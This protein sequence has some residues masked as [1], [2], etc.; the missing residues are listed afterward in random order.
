MSRVSFFLFGLF[1]AFGASAAPNQPMPVRGYADIHNHMF[2]E[3]AYGGAWYHGSAVGPEEIALAACDVD[4]DLLGLFEKHG[5]TKIPFVNR[6]ITDIR[7]GHADSGRHE[8]RRDG[9]PTYEGWPRWDTMSHQQVWEGWLKSAHEK[10]LSLVVISAVNFEPLCQL[11]PEV[12]RKVS[13]NDMEAV[14]RQIAAVHE[15]AKKHPWAVV[16]SSPAEARRAIGS[17]KLALVLSLEVTNLFGKE[18]WEVA[19]ERY[20]AKGVRTLQTAHQL[21]NRF[22]GVAIHNFIFKIFQ[23]FQDLK[24]ARS[25]W[26]YLPWKL[27]FERDQRGHNV[28]GLTEEGQALVLGLMKRGWLI[29]IAHSSEK[30]VKDTAAIAARF[31]QEGD[32]GYPVYLSHGHFRN[33]MNDGKFSHYEKS[34]DDWVLDLVANSGGIFGLR[35]GPEK[36]KRYEKGVVPND[37]QG[38]T[39]SFA[40]TYQYGDREKR[41]AIAFGSDLNGFIQQTRPRFGGFE[42][43]C[44]A[45]EDP[46]EQERQRLAQTGK[47]GT[48]FDQSGFGRVD[49][50]ADIVQELKNFGVD[51]TNLESSAENFIRMWERAEKLSRD[52]RSE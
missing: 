18:N 17:G 3:L 16:V 19:L 10:G 4:V 20:S 15:F 45:E 9:Y 52:F 50:M 28:E 34:S 48:R 14:D 12:N 23:I 26:D 7:G 24:S 27:G 36:T 37:C 43:T 46:A 21:N 6:L 13:C 42:E 51:T 31:G 49:Q 29:D 2:A 25:F 40:Q 44:G 22:T 1:L 11:M 47:L 41:L 5:R 30:A 35:T 33:M 32:G 8:G 39:K 38:S